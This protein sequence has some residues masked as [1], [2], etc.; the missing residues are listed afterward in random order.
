MNA[1]RVSD[2]DEKQKRAY[3]PFRQDLGATQVDALLSLS[4]SYESQHLITMCRCA[5][6]CPAWLTGTAI[7]RPRTGCMSFQRPCS[8]SST[9]MCSNSSMMSGRK[10]SVDIW[11]RRLEY[12]ILLSFNSHNYFQISNKNMTRCAWIDT[13]DTA[14]GSVQ[15]NHMYIPYRANR[16][17]KSIGNKGVV[18]SKRR[19]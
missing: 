17:A 9:L 19:S 15:R 8:S 13:A 14:F 1:W 11:L 5:S 18:Y 6:T 16:A 4:C 3:I 2:Y 7:L 10:L 12:R